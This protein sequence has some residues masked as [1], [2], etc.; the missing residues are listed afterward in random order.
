VRKRYNTNLGFDNFVDKRLEGA[1]KITKDSYE[2]GGTSMLTYYHYDAKL[3]FYLDAAGGNFDIE[4]AKEVFD[5]LKSEISYDMP[6]IDFQKKM[7]AMEVLGE[8]I[9]KQE[10]KK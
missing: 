6:Q 3:Q 8:L 5:S 2:K 9:I 7:G 4:A 10:S 1:K